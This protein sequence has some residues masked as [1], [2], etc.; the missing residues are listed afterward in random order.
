[1]QF[2][3]RFV[4]PGPGR[5]K[6]VCFIFGQSIPLSTSPLPGGLAGL[7]RYLASHKCPE[8]LDGDASFERIG[9]PD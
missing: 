9:Y 4:A 2:S 6:P 5:F 3:G 1:M 8:M 7:G